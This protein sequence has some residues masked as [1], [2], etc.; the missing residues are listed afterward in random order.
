MK[1]LI[2]TAFLYGLV[3]LLAGVFYREFTKFS[4]YEGRTVLSVLHPHLLILGTLLFLLLALFVRQLP[5]L[6]EKSFVTFYRLHS[7]ALPAVVLMLG[8][9]GVLQTRQVDVAKGLDAAISGLAGLSHVLLTVAFVF[10]FLALK[11]AVSRVPDRQ[12]E[13]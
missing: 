13:P 11:R 3:G 4:G 9:R 2:N 7:V 6:E 12:P 8:V 10:L 5:L 1:R